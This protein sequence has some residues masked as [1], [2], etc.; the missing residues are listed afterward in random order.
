MN[1]LEKAREPEE[2]LCLAKQWFNNKE[3]P[4]L[5][6]TLAR[7]IQSYAE[8]YHAERCKDEQEDVKSCRN[9]GRDDGD[10]C[11]GCS[12]YYNDLWLPAAPKKE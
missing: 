6:N 12:R 5:V 9:C 8:A 1:K 7:D 11:H 2:A 3:I 4:S 10:F